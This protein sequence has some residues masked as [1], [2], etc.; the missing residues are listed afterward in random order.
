MICDRCQQEI[1]AGP[2]E[3]CTRQLGGE[4]AVTSYSK[5]VRTVHLETTL[6]VYA[7]ATADPWDDALAAKERELGLEPSK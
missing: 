1:G 3:S 5:H 6:P 4:F 7:T 2:C